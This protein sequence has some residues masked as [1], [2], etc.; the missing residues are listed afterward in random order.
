MKIHSNNEWDPLK[1][2]IVGN[3]FDRMAIENDLSF[4][5]FFKD[6]LYG[7]LQNSRELITIKEQYITELKEDLAEF[8]KVLEANGVNV[9]RPF[10]MSTPPT[11]TVDGKRVIGSPALNVR[12]QCIIIDDAIVQTAPCQRS[13]YYENDLLLHI[14]GDAEGRQISMPKSDMRD[15]NF[16]TELIEYKRSVTKGSTQDEITNWDDSKFFK[17][18]DFI[19]EIPKNIQMMIDGANCVRFGDDIIINISNR[20]QYLGYVWFLNNFPEKNWHPIYSL[21][22]NH[23]DSF[24]VPLCEGVLLLRNKQFLEQM[25]DFLKSWKIIYPPDTTPQFPTYTDSDAMLTSTYIDM[26]VLSLD[27]RKII[28]NTLYPELA[29]LLYKEGFDPIPV[30]HRHRRI[31]AGGFHCFTL[32][33]HREKQ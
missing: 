20:N 7:W 3:V 18:T 10:P 28:C 25:P 24:I 8:V 12:D 23:L 21:C 22:D 19:G 9:H 17:D 16:D 33:L 13:R 30:Q 2:V 26:N 27:G 11:Y 29:E 1:E 15:E 31:F 14:F 4:Q 6:N 5:L 32:D